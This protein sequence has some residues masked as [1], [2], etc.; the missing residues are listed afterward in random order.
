MCSSFNLAIGFSPIFGK[1]IFISNERIHENIPIIIAKNYDKWYTRMNVVF[2]YQ[3]F[4]EVI[5]NCVN[6]LVEGAMAAQRRLEKIFQ[7]FVSHSSIF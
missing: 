2:G 1:L 6:P 3:D 5:K 7:S 4:L